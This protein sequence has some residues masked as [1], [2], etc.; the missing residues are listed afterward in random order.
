MNSRKQVQQIRLVSANQNRGLS[1][2]MKNGLRV[3]D[4]LS[5]RSLGDTA[6]PP[7]VTASIQP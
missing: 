4:V 7:P 2:L 3:R 6:A 5:P 1:R